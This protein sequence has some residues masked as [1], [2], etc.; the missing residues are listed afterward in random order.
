ML[1]WGLLLKRSAPPPIPAMER[2]EASSPGRVDCRECVRWDCWPASC[3]LPT[4]H[5][6]MALTQN[7]GPMSSGPQFEMW[8]IRHPWVCTGPAPGKGRM[9]GRALGGGGGVSCA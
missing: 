1:P 6:T 4:T 5:V 3:D 9:T 2:T 7:P 8:K